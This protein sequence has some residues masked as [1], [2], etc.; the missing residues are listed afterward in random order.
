M[1]VR[2]ETAQ[3]VKNQHMRVEA[4]FLSEARQ[5]SVPQPPRMARVA[6][7]LRSS[8]PM[9]AARNTSIKPFR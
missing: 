4:N 7:I 6:P 5:C 1:S 2:S 3:T 9:A 8:N